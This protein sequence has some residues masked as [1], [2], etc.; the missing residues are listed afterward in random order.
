MQNEGVTAVAVNET[1]LQVIR[2]LVKRKNQP[3]SRKEPKHG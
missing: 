3:P 1:T 2:D